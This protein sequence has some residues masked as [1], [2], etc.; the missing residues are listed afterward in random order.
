[1]I[2]FLDL[3]RIMALS[4]SI[5]GVEITNHSMSGTAPYRGQC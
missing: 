4:E 5:H 1:M 3:K 2:C